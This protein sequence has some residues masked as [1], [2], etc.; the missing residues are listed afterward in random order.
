MLMTAFKMFLKPGCKEIYKKRH[1]EIWPEL[2]ELLLSKGISNYYIF[3]DETT[4]TL[5]AVQEQAGAGSSQ[6]LGTEKIVQEW[7]NFMADIMVVNPDNS[8]VTE[9]LEQMFH[10]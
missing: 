4:N 2:K 7:W 5:F 6:D 10:L 1:D 3:L 9:P 8:P